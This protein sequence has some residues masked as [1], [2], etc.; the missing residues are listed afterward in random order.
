MPERFVRIRRYGIYNHTIIRNLELQFVPK[1]VEV[2]REINK[3]TET[4]QERIKRLTGFDVCKCPAC[5]VGTMVSPTYQVTCRKPAF[6]PSL[7][8][9]VNPSM[10]QYKPSYS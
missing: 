7:Q 9:T 8:V 3:K 4:K 10:P 5:K 1:Q 6:N 2:A